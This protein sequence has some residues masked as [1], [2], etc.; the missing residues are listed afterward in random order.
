MSRGLSS[1]NAT[2]SAA[3]HVR[4]LPFIKCEFDSG[5]LYLHLGVGT[6]RW[7]PGGVGTGDTYTGMGALGQIG[8]LDEGT[9]LSPFGVTM[10]LNALDSTLLALAEGE[11]VFNRRVTTY[12]GFLDE[13]GALVDTPAERWSGW[14]DSLG[15]QLGGDQDGIELQ[16]ESEMRFSDRTNGARFTDE[17]QQSRYPSDIMFQYLAQIVD[18]RVPWGPSGSVAAVGP[19]SSPGRGPPR[20][21]TPGGTP[22]PP[23]RNQGP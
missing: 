13:N 17:D 16:C 9:D 12:T 22:T 14:G 2:A 1:P 23:I 7:G 8:S 6:Y 20:Y 10:R 18:A 4:P 19:P 3:L 21:Q 15:L 5:T 11:E